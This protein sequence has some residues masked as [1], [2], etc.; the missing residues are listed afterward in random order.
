LKAESKYRK[1]ALAGDIFNAGVIGLVM[2][3]VD[4]ANGSVFAYPDEITVSFGGPA[5][6][7]TSP[8]AASP[9]TAPTEKT[10]TESTAST[11]TTPALPN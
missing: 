10:T 6:P 3:G 9:S 7:L 2:Y 11:N 4:R 1:G 8:D 5:A